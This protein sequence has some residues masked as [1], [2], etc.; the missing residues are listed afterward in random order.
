MDEFIVCFEDAPT[1]KQSCLCFIP[2]LAITLWVGLSFNLKGPRCYIQ[3]FYVPTLDLSQTTSNSTTIINPSLFFDVTLKNILDDHSI[4]YG[5]VNLTFSY[6]QNAV[7]NYIVPSFYQGKGK[8]AHRREVVE[9]RGMPWDDALRAVSNGSKAVFRVDL[10][11]KPRFRFWFWYSRKKGV[12]IG[13]NVE[14]DGSGLKV[15]KDDIRL[16]F[17]ASKGS[18]GLFALLLSLSVT[19][20]LFH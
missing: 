6:G 17:A 15:H 19:L 12:R 4:R 20:V 18:A 14:V 9:A 13:A 10:A 8:T 5:D 3:E 2:T 11:A 1:D 7:A 16:N